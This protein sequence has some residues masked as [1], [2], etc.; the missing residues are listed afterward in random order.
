MG[1]DVRGDEETFLD[2]DAGETTDEE[3]SKPP[4]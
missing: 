2:R 3:Y 4:D 1:E